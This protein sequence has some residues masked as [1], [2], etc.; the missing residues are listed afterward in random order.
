MTVNINVEGIDKDYPVPGIDNSSQ[1]FRD[2]FNIIKTNFGVIKEEIIDIKNNNARIDQSNNFGNNKII[3]AV[4]SNTT[5]ETNIPGGTGDNTSV[6]VSW[7]SGM[8]HV[9]TVDTIDGEIFPFTPLTVNLVNWPSQN[10]LYAKMTLIFK[11]NGTGERTV[12]WSP[13][14]KKN[15]NIISDISAKPSKDVIVEVFTFNA[16][17][18]VYLNLIGDFE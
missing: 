2:N 14:V 4:L 13:N 18:D 17:V 12:L 5:L 9:I 10:N 6:E 15:D 16:G 3:E 8:V 7:N 1:G 11:R